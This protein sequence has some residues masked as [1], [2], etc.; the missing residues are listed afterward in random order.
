MSKDL[1]HVFLFF[2]LLLLQVFILNN[3][4]LFGYVNPY[5]YIAFVFIYPVRENRFPFLTY[6]FLL[7][8]F[9]DFFTDSGGTNAF[10]TLFIAYTRLYFF[11]R[12]FQKSESEY[13]L[14]SLQKE[15]FGSV[16]NYV[17]ILTITHHFLIF[18]LTNFSFNNF[19]N[20]ISNTLLSSTFTL[21]LYF[22]GSFIFS[23]KQ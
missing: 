5:I 23:K 7:G 4:L 3:I 8:L 9:V 21:A 13:E 12:I 22:I 2:F 15:S 6:S 20:V 1:Y 17:A 18:S 10:A 16:F 11:K 19:S 14:F